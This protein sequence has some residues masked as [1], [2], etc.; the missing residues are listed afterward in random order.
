MEKKEY[1]P[2][3]TADDVIKWLTYTNRPVYTYNTWDIKYGSPPNVPRCV[4][5]VIPKDDW[6]KRTPPGVTLIPFLVIYFNRSTY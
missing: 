5:N 6:L 2:M 3:E 1:K 4:K